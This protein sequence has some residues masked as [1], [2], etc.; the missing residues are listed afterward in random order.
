MLVGPSMT[1]AW[2]ESMV[3][4]CQPHGKIQRL[5]VGRRLG[6]G[7]RVGT[8]RRA[9]CSR[10]FVRSIACGCSDVSGGG[11]RFIRYRLRSFVFASTASGFDRANAGATGRIN[12]PDWS[13]LLTWYVDPVL[14]E[15]PLKLLDGYTLRVLPSED[16]VLPLVYLGLITPTCWH[17][18]RRT[19]VEHLGRVPVQTNLPNGTRR[20][21]IS[22]QYCCGSLAASTFMLASG[23]DV[24]T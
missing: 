14:T 15:W 3:G 24:W 11:W 4:S 16:R 1:S 7:N 13:A 21:L 19:Q 9:S 20:S 17:I 23:V 12:S 2:A 8:G 18:E 10:L 22:I 6:I 5:M